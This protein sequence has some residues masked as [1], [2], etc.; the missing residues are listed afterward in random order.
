VA[1]Y[2]NYFLTTVNDVILEVGYFQAS[3]SALNDARQK[4]LDAMMGQ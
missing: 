4:L 3:D 1:S 2:I